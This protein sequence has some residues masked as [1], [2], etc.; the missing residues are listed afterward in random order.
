[1]AVKDNVPVLKRMEE[2]KKQ[3]TPSTD[4]GQI[5]K[6]FYAYSLEL[7]PPVYIVYVALKDGRNIRLSDCDLSQFPSKEDKMGLTIAKSWQGE[8]PLQVPN[9]NEKRERG[10]SCSIC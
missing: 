5:L 9:P 2:H 1:M 10:P 4:T 8:I 6:I 7:T 3:W